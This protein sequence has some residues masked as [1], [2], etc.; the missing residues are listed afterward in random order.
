MVSTVVNG[1]FPDVV[2]DA[3]EN[4]KVLLWGT[5]TVSLKY[6]NPEEIQF[7]VRPSIYERILKKKAASDAVIVTGAGA[8][9]KCHQSFL[10]EQSPVF[11]AMLERSTKKSGTATVNMDGITDDNLEALL[12]FLYYDDATEA[13]K[14]SEVAL[15]LLEVGRRFEIEELIDAMKA[16]ILDEYDAWFSMD[17]AMKLFTLAWNLT[18]GEELKEKAVNILKK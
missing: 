13:E 10:V 1:V 17:M 16:I 9:I 12:A 18:D 3:W 8:R 14:N 5:L 2:L 7:P 11:K 6:D 15:E 4:P